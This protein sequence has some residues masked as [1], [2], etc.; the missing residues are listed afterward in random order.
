MF[1]KVEGS[2]MT[3]RKISAK[4]LLKD[5]RKGI[6]DSELMKKYQVSQQGL[7]KLFQKLVAAGRLSQSDINGR[8]QPTKSEY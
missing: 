1:T 6:N 3:Q 4:E 2:V 7:H 8:F 5:I